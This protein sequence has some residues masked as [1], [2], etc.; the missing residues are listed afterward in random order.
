MGAKEDIKKGTK[1]MANKV[2]DAA[3]NLADKLS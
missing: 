3:G 2:S 1:S